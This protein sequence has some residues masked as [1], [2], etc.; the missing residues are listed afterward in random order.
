VALFIL[1]T[2]LHS[3]VAAMFGGRIGH[4]GCGQRSEV[5]LFG[6]VIAGMIFTTSSGATFFFAV[7]T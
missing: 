3:F 1:G 4:G 7:H 5:A 2:L 6:S